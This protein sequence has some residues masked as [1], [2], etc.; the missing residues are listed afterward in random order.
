PPPIV[1]PAQT[2]PAPTPLH[3]LA[4]LDQ[5]I[6]DLASQLHQNE[7]ETTRLSQQ[8]IAAAEQSDN[9]E[10]KAQAETGQPASDDYLAGVDQQKKADDLAVQ[11]ETLAANQANLQAELSADQTERAGVQSAI[12]GYQKRI[13]QL[14]AEWNSTQDAVASLTQQINAFVNGPM[15]DPS[16]KPLADQITAIKA[17]LADDRKTRGDDAAPKLAEAVRWNNQAAQFCADLYRSLPSADIDHLTPVEVDEQQEYKEAFNSATYYLAACDAQLA[18]AQN[19][20]AET[21]TNLAANDALR[22]AQDVLGSIAPGSLN[23]ALAVTD[24]PDVNKRSA[25]MGLYSL[26]QLQTF[27]NEQF[28]TALKDYE[29]F[30]TTQRETNPSEPGPAEDRQA[31]GYVGH[32]TALYTARQLA[33]AEGATEIAGIELGDIQSL[34]D[35]D[36]SQIA[37]IDRSMLPPI[38]NS[39]VTAALETPAPP[40]PA[41]PSVTNNP[42]QE[43]P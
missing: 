19:A 40:T 4:Y 22:H 27:A 18:A 30:T 42:D 8:K 39:E 23:D 34:I 16:Q 2:G 25:K 36:A 11:L 12:D 33:S 29:S 37:A 31:A 26:N 1:I 35:Q 9:L 10:Q 24:P 6:A 32:M 3:T 38:P 15:D 41:A 28:A 5:R 20:A 21:M 43:G 17:L 14:T 13:A 7:A